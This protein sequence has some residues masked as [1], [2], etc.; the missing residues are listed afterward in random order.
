MEQVNFDMM[1][2]EHSDLGCE[3]GKTCSKCNQFLP[4]DKFN[5]ASGGNYLRA[6]CR[7]CNNEMQ[8]LERWLAEAESMAKD[9]ENHSLI[10]YHHLKLLQTAYNSKRKQDMS[11]GLTDV[12]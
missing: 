9:L 7:S 11:E 1:L 2:H 12:S 8:S 5:F 3:D 6:E 10:I 4:L